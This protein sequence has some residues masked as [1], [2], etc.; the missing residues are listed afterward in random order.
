MLI[1]NPQHR[2]LEEGFKERLPA[3]SPPADPSQEMACTLEMQDVSM[4]A[5]DTPYMTNDRYEYLNG[6][7][8]MNFSMISIL[9]VLEPCY[10]SLKAASIRHPFFG[11]YHQTRIKCMFARGSNAYMV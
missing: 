4:N 6:I 5:S 10:S 8:A 9:N 2:D 1:L 7:F 11:G 3:R